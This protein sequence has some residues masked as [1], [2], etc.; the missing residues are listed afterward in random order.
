[1]KLYWVGWRIPKLEHVPEIPDESVLGWWC[2]W[3][4]EQGVSVLRAAVAADSPQEAK[5]VVK[6][7]WPG[8]DHF[9][10]CGE[11]TPLWIPDSAYP[12]LPWMKDRFQA[13]QETH[14]PA[15]AMSDGEKML[16]ALDAAMKV[17]NDVK[18]ELLVKEMI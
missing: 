6:N 1:M 2:M 14:V 12:L 16:A 10:V 5:Q 8:V 17:L 13:F 3:T 9:P 18:T 4:T 15:P 7:N 11:Q